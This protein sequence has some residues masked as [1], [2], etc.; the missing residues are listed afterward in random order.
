[1]RFANSDT[2]LRHSRQRLDCACLKHR[3]LSA[4]ARPPSSHGS[5][6][7]EAKAP[8]KPDALHALRELRHGLVSLASVATG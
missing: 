8:V 5:L 4:A 7:P 3:F 2:G 6:C 1:M